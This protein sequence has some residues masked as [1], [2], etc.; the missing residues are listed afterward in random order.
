MNYHDCQNIDYGT[1]IKC[2]EKL[3]WVRMCTSEITISKTIE[4]KR[5]ANTSIIVIISN[6]I[7]KVDRNEQQR[8]KFLLIQ[9]LYNSI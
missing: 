1:Y 9:G 6:K 7:C 8:K 4:R 5:P 2:N 3:E